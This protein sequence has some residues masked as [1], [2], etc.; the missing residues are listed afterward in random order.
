MKICLPCFAALVASMRPAA[1]ET[2]FHVAPT[3]SDLDPG[4]RR[5]AF[6]TLE[7]A[8][9]A[10]RMEK[11]C[12]GSVRLV[13]RAF[14]GR[15]RHCVVSHSRS[16]VSLSDCF[17]SS[18]GRQNHRGNFLVEADGGRLQVRGCSFGSDEPG[19]ALRR[20]LQHAIVT[21]NNGVTGVEVANEIGERAVLANNEPRSNPAK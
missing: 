5:K 16:Y 11:T 19:I 6:A 12:H 2:V 20:G 15:A 21:E 17:L 8:R 9:Q 18:T 14:W 1:A 4:T 10:V 7:R 13:N 3:G